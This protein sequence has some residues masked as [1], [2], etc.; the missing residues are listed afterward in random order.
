MSLAESFGEHVRLVGEI[1]GVIEE[2]SPT[3]NHLAHVPTTF[4]LDPLTARGVGD[5]REPERKDR[6]EI[7]RGRRGV[8][9]SPNALFASPPGIA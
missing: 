8:R 4:A 3:M 5:A 7:E 9:E 6:R 1:E 2:K